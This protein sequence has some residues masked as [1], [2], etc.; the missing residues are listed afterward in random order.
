LGDASNL[1]PDDPTLLDPQLLAGLRGDATARRAAVAKLYAAF[2][3]R[4][5]RYYLN[6]RA[7]PAQADD[8]TQETFVRILRS[9]GDFEGHGTQFAAW[10]WTI[11]RNVSL[12]ALRHSS[13][14][15]MADIDELEDAEAPVQEDGD[16]LLRA[17]TDSVVDCVQIGFR[18]FARIH[19]QRAQCLSWLASD[20]M[21]IE[22][23]ASVLGRTA[24]ATRE[25]LSQC[26]KK[27][28]PYIEHCWAAA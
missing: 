14:R 27:L 23:I 24:A 1:P 18:E 10:V 8:W 3:G 28:R 4:L 19:P 13:S 2:A 11:A 12:D 5:R 16:P 26:R 9:A 20:R 15:P 17:E 25:Y 7:T 21:D 6:H 22:Q